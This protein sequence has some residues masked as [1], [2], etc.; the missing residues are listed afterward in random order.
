MMQEI[1]ILADTF[2]SGRLLV[3]LEGG[4][5]VE[6]GLPYTNLGII[7]AMAGLDLSSIREPD[8]LLEML[9]RSVSEQAIHTVEKMAADLK[10]IH[11]QYWVCFR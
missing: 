10:Q 1:C 7:A 8:T 5:S 9:Q 2:C 3:I 4:Y 6:G 11:R